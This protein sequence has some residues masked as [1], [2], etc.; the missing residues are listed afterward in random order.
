[1]QNISLERLAPTRGVIVTTVPVTQEPES[2]LGIS[3]PGPSR[4]VVREC[5]RQL[6]KGCSSL[7]PTSQAQMIDALR[8]TLTNPPGYF[9]YPVE[10]I[11]LLYAVTAESHG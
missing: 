4:G 9:S 8:Y 3:R 6:P 2:E 5:S 1:M 7:P 10:P 11:G